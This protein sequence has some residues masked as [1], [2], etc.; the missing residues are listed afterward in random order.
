LLSISIAKKEK[1]KEADSSNNIDPVAKTS[2]VV[3]LVCLF[4][5]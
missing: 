1:E 2:V 5:V 3:V 4:F